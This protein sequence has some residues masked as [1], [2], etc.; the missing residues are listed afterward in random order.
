MKGNFQMAGGVITLPAL[1]YTVP[2][3]VIDLKGT[4]GVD[5][6]TLDFAGT[7]KMQATVSQMVGGWKGLLLKPAGP[8]LP[9]RRSGDGGSDSHR[10]HARESAV[11][12]RFQPDEE[13]FA[14]TAGHPPMKSRVF[15]LPACLLRRRDV[16]RD[17]LA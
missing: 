5:G 9:E 11:R 2:G 14:A 15:G 1:K 6:G 13:D 16:P 7:A 12:D 10:W 8:L 3:A 17:N 4:Y